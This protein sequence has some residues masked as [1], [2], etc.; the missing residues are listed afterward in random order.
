MLES[1]SVATDRLRREGRW[2]KASLWRDQKRVQLRAEGQTRTESNEAAWQAMIEQFPPLPQS[3]LPVGDHAVELL[4]IDPDSYD[5]QSS[6]T[7]DVAWV[8]QYLSVKSAAPHQAPSSGA[9]GLLQWARRNSDRFFML[10]LKVGPHQVEPP[11]EP[12]KHPGSAEIDAMLASLG[13]GAPGDM[14]PAAQ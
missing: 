1:K 7:D 6:C 3:E 4:D 13:K 14:D 2:E 10:W 9:W 8:Y 5:G 11:F 12:W